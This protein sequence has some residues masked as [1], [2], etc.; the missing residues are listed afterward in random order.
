M[1]TT[2]KSYLYVGLAVVL[3]ASTAAVGKLLLAGL[4][5]IQVTFYSFAFSIVSLFVI[6]AF[7]GKLR[8]LKQYHTRDYFRMAGMGFL[9]CYLYF[10]LLF[11]ALQYAPAQEAFI[12]NYLWPMMVVIFAILILKEK[13]TIRK[14]IGLALGFMGIYFV[15]T[16]G[17]VLNFSFSYLKGDLLAFLAALS[18]GLFSV[19]GKKF[20]YETFSS[21]LIYYCFGFVFVLATLLFFSFLPTISLKQFLGLAWLG[22]MTNALAFVFWF[23]ALEGGDTAKMANIIFLTPFLSLVYIY[24][25]VGEEILFSSF[26]GLVLIVGGIVIQSFRRADVPLASEKTGNRSAT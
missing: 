26:V 20:K 10:I 9:G 18:Y 13:L 2:K 22:V 8:L 15:A 12:V 24:F 6:T 21:M 16:R 3:W 17:E 14:L 23:K 19:L 5:N 4:N 7:Q 1:T 11:G 25:L